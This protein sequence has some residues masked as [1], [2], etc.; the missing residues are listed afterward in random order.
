M[1]EPYTKQRF[2]NQ[3]PTLLCA[4][5]RPAGSLEKES[6]QLITRLAQ[7]PTLIRERACRFSL[8]VNSCKSMQAASEAQEPWQ[9][10]AHP[11]VC[12]RPCV[13]MCLTLFL[14]LDL[15]PTFHFST[16]AF[17]FQSLAGHTYTQRC[18]APAK[19]LASPRLFIPKRTQTGS[20]ATRIQTAFE[21]L[22]N[23]EL[24][25]SIGEGY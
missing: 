20:Q 14:P 19:T 15:S 4:P 6:V 11:K 17:A 24:Y 8:C 25:A 9:V 18:L 5:W 2:L 13:R 3:V 12:E 7:R 16:H 21:T 10:C 22:V 23:R 1:I